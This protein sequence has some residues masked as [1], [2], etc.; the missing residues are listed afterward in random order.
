MY[1]V[2]TDGNALYYMRARYYSPEILR[3]INQDILLGF[4]TDGQTLNRYAFVTGQPVSLVDPFG[5]DGM[6]VGMFP[7]LGWDV[8]IS[9]IHDIFLKIPR[10]ARRTAKRKVGI[11]NGGVDDPQDAYRHCFASCLMTMRHGR[12]LAETLGWLNEL[13]TSIQFQEAESRMM[14]DHNNWCGFNYGEVATSSQQCET[15]CWSGLYNGELVREVEPDFT[16]IVWADLFEKI[17]WL[18][19]Q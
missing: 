5:F 14:D 7:S 3:F 15:L 1:G 6:P 18:L 10:D 19:S 17:K 4:V 16:N 8:I 11:P 13:K 12:Q 2:M 9:K